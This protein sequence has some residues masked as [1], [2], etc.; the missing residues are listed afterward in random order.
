MCPTIKTTTRGCTGGTQR[1]SRRSGAAP[2]TASSGNPSH[3]GRPVSIRHRPPKRRRVPMAAAQRRTRHPTNRPRRR[4]DTEKPPERY[5][6]RGGL[7]RRAASPHRRRDGPTSAT[8]PPS[9]TVLDDRNAPD[10]TARRATNACH[11]GE[12]LAPVTTRGTRDGPGQ[13]SALGVTRPPERPGD[14]RATGAA[15]PHSGASGH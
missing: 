11:G 6:R 10:R 4:R 1:R 12:R 15:H 9:D 8:G 13:S 2:L 14:G 7:S 3:P 5:D